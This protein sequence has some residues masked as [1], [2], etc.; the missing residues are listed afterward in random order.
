MRRAEEAGV[1]LAWG[2][3]ATGV[4]AERGEV[5]TAD[6]PLS[7][8]LVVGA[9]GLRSRLRRWAGLDGEPAPVRRF[10]VRRHFAIAP[11]SDFVEVSWG[12]AC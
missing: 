5:A 6:G 2:M 9:D 3:I 11:W 7:A 10:G 4:D 8:R 1:E 12:P